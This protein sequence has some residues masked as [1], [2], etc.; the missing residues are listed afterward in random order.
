M[1]CVGSS[2]TE[3][4]VPFMTPQRA[5]S[6]CVLSFFSKFTLQDLPYTHKKGTF[7]TMCCC[8]SFLFFFQITRLCFV[9]RS[10]QK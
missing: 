7:L 6:H 8:F 3:V 4:L 2:T 10:G 5:N 1:D 9:D